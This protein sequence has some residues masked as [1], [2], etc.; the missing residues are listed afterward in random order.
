MQD[1]DTLMLEDFGH[2]FANITGFRLIEYNDR[3]V[4]DILQQMAAYHAPDGVTILDHLDPKIIK[5][6]QQVIR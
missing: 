3:K 4:N 1:L 5:V 6:L 2:N